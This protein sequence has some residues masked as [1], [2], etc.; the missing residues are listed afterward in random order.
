MS[1]STDEEHYYDLDDTYF[2]DAVY[3]LGLEPTATVKFLKEKEILPESY[4]TTLSVSGL[5]QPMVELDEVFYE[6]IVN[7]CSTAN[8]LVILGLMG[9]EEWLECD[10]NP[11]RVRIPKG[12]AVGFFDANYGGGSML[13]MRLIR[14][15]EIELDK[16]MDSS[17]H[18]RWSLYPDIGSRSVKEVYY[19]TNDIY[20]DEI[21]LVPQQQEQEEKL[22]NQH[23]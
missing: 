5:I 19:C 23:A 22:D 21:S 14:D 6:E 11:S 7:S 12:N 2:G 8:N 15:V 4:E 9:L 1:C 18:L 13:D 17:G 3:A 20:G 10:G 16:P